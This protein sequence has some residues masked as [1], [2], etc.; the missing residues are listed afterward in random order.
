MRRLL[1]RIV[2][3]VV[4]LVAAVGAAALAG[5]LWLRPFIESEASAILGRPI[6]IG[7]LA[8]SL[9]SVAPLIID[10]DNGDVVIGN[11][12]AFPA[13]AEPL[14]RIARMIVSLDVL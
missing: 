13:G 8:L 2:W 5:R 10:F 1:Q 6:T 11:P 12:Q 9:H 4:L 3:G 7:S 14:A